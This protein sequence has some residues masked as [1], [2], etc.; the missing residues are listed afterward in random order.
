[1]PRAAA[2]IRTLL[3][4]EQGADFNRSSDPV[5]VAINSSRGI[6]L[7]ALITLALLSCRVARKTKE[8]MTTAWEMYVRDFDREMLLTNKGVYEFIPFY[9][10]HL[11]NFLFMSK[12]WTDAQ[13]DKVFD[14]DNQ[15]KWLLAMQSFAH[16]NASYE[17]LYLRLKLGGDWPSK[18]LKRKLEIESF[19]ILHLLISTAKSGSMKTEVSL[20]YF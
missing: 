9:L 16:V 4:R 20:N 11:A 3:A 13:F 6:C 19:N 17:P 2:L 10:I 15:T 7:S 14:Q 8:S 1:V 5:T 12:E 18:L